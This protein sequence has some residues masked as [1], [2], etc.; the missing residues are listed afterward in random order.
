MV[1]RSGQALQIQ[2]ERP[3]RFKVLTGAEALRWLREE[4][5]RREKLFPPPPVL[6][7]PPV[8]RVDVT[9]NGE[10]NGQHQREVRGR[11]EPPRR[12]RERRRPPRPEGL[13]PILVFIE[14]SEGQAPVPT[15]LE[16][17]ARWGMEWVQAL[18]TY[19]PPWVVPFPY[20]L[21][22]EEDF[23]YPD[24]KW[25]D[26]WIE[27]WGILPP[28]DNEAVIRQ[29][30]WDGRRTFDPRR[31]KWIRSPVSEAT[32]RKLLG[33]KF[34]LGLELEELCHP[35][36]ASAL[37]RALVAA[38]RAALGNVVELRALLREEDGEGWFEEAVG[39][40]AVQEERD[41]ARYYRDL[42]AEYVRERAGDD[43]FV[44][45]VGQ[46]FCAQC[47][48]WAIRSV[49]P[50]VPVGRRGIPGG[51]SL[52]SIG[53][54]PVLMLDELLYRTTWGEARYCATCGKPLVGRQRLYCSERCKWKLHKRKVRAKVRA[55]VG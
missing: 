48:R 24:T 16:D 47:L 30:A 49:Q 52:R 1:D 32:V 31:K 25:V 37:A 13:N 22:A 29:L 38:E 21:E 5:R 11:V 50:H 9:E 19:G 28:W 46:H 18:E 20:A 7:P 42:R 55:A 17:V 4:A 44:Q 54:L 12:P 51:W 27:K 14:K 41:G 35:Y 43:G 23:P 45:R 33:P 40:V 39:R 2:I 8:H 34:V 6:P 3:Y 15:T 36:G 53:W 10:L 26:Y